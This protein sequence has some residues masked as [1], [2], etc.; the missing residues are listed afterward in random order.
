MSISNFWRIGIGIEIGI[1]LSIGIGKKFGIGI[2][3]VFM[4]ALS[5]TFLSV[6]N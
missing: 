4:A 3:L 1:F 6:K 2:S 5:T